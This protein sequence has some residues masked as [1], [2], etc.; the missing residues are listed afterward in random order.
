EYAGQERATAGLGFATGAFDLAQYRRLVALLGGQEIFLRGFEAF[1]PEADKALLR[2]TLSGEA[3]AGEAAAGEAVAEVERMR[4]VALEAGPGGDLQG[5]AGSRWFEVATAR[6][7]L[8]K[9]VEDRVAS[10]LDAL[11]DAIHAEAAG[12]F[13]RL[14]GAVAVLLVLTL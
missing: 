14:L 6:I 11:A 13:Y 8:L 5:I 1:A 7:D 10:G 12:A 2:E 4:R 9:Q 3:E